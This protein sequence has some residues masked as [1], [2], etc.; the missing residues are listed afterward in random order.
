ME[1]ARLWGHLSMSATAGGVIF[2]DFDGTLAHRPGMWRGCL[3]TALAAVDPGHVASE[4]AIRRGLSDGFPWHAPSVAHLEMR[5]SEQW[6]SRLMPV[7]VAALEGAGVT[8]HIAVA[9]ARLAPQ[10]YSD[11][12]FWHVFDDTPAA[13]ALLKANGWRTQA[14]SSAAESP[15]RVGGGRLADSR[16]LGLRGETC[17]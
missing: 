1:R 10:I 4:D 16:R 2:W 8:P 13:L 7:L 17:L 5:T 11:P 14:P 3:L 15:K 6:W 12:Q 9:A